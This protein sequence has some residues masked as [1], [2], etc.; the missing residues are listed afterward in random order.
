MPVD[1]F[2]QNKSH[3]N[4]LCNGLRLWVE[5]RGAD[6]CIAKESF[7]PKKVQKDKP[8]GVQPKQKITQQSNN[9]VIW[10]LN[11]YMYLGKYTHTLTSNDCVGE[12]QF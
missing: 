10:C 8:I 11:R 5:A 7:I 4:Q 9:V 12:I 6:G 1:G 2:P 3:Y